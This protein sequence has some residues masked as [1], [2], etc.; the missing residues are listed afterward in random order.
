ML[1]ASLSHPS[2]WIRDLSPQTEKHAWNLPKKTKGTLPVA[3]GQ[4]H[5]NS[6]ASAQWLNWNALELMSAHIKSCAPGKRSSAGNLE[7]SAASRFSL[8]KSASRPR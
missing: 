6:G 2:G 3:H 8:A 1:R 5:A 7:V 4:D